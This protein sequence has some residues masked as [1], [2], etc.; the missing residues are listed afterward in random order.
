MTS[1]GMPSEGVDDSE[2][3]RWLAAALLFSTLFWLIA[4]YWETEVSM[5]TI[6]IR[7][8]TFAHG[9][10]IVPISVWMIWQRR[11]QLSS[12]DFR[13]SYRVLPLL[14][15][16][17]FGWLL[18][19]LAG[20]RVVQQFAVVLMVPIIVWS[21]LGTQ[22]ARTL[23]FP[24]LFLLL[25]VPFGEF[26]TETLM[27]H[28]ADF[29]ISALRLTGIPVYREGLF[30]T[31][32]SGSWSVIE[33]CSGLRYLMASM[34]LG[35]LYAYLT[36]RSFKRRAAFV[37]ASVVV[38][39]VAN[40]LRA[41]MIVMIGHLTSMKYAV[42]IDHLI[43]GW[44][45]FGI[46]M[47]LLFWVGSFWREDI[48]GGERKALGSP[49]RV[50]SP[51]GLL[52]A[53]SCAA[54]VVALGPFTAGWM[55]PGHTVV[56]ELAA[57]PSAGSWKPIPELLTEWTPHF[58]RP[59][60]EFDQVY[61]DG[62]RKV[63][64]RVQYYPNRDADPQLISSQNVLVSLGD[65]T[66]KISGESMRTVSVGGQAIG[67]VETQLRSGSSRLLVWRWYWIDGTFTVSPYLGKLLQARSALLGR[68]SGGAIIL[69]YA[70]LGEGPDGLERAAA[71]M[72]DFTGAAMYAV[73]GS[74]A[75]A[76]IKARLGPLEY[77]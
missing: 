46:V 53:A 45:F 38:P 37:A 20:A 8:E 11:A 62:D 51:G 50:P 21:I 57:P 63:A 30:F 4:W 69:V 26:L 31:I 2:R 65:Q 41:Y 43:Y 25:A 64:L 77:R 28:T 56:E 39:I 12:V 40:W 22:V 18:G 17:G 36:Y 6:W 7:S 13:P 14:A 16:A 29:T 9:F 10:L 76:G 70:K 71:A 47:M 52:I 44:L 74:L 67:T 48:T 33:A 73:A 3:V 24:L 66:W 59:Q 19:D 35:L 49:G 27:Q 1:L 60:A 75:K 61:S 34:T 72:H 68:G 55:A 54:A 5:V 42:G 32:P 23:R 15:L 58:A